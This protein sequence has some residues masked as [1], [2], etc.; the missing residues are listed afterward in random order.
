MNTEKTNELKALSGMEFKAHLVTWI[1]ILVMLV[2]ALFAP[3]FKIKFELLDV[4]AS[5]NM[6]DIYE[7]CKEIYQEEKENSI[8]N[9][10]SDDTSKKGL[11]DTDLTM[12]SVQY[13]LI[14]AIIFIVVIDMIF[15][16]VGIIVVLA[17]KKHWSLNNEASCIPMLC[18]FIASFI[19][20]TTLTLAL[21]FLFACYIGIIVINAMANYSAYTKKIQKTYLNTRCIFGFV[22][23]GIQLIFAIF[24]LEILS[25]LN[26]SNGWMYLLKMLTM[27]IIIVSALSNIS[28]GII[29]SNLKRYATFGLFNIISLIPIQMVLICILLFAPNGTFGLSDEIMLNL[30]ICIV[31]AILFIVSV[32]VE[33]KK[34]VKHG[35][36]ENADILEMFD[37]KH[38]KNEKDSTQNVTT[39]NGKPKAESSKADNEDAMREKL[40]EELKEELIKELM[41]EKNNTDNNK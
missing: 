31:A 4:E 19:F 15:A 6:I 41:K 38:N 7:M 23:F 30:V 24:S 8:P 17:T 26:S 21:Y 32:V 35:F 1:V 3:I 18:I 10:S 36:A 20:P 12:T 27:L 9:V 37:G 22:N 14:L 29:L 39:G 13:L 28:R 2:T 40:K 33:R 11:F 25:E 34:Y 16:V 5:Y